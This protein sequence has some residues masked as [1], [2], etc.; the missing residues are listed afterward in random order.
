MDTGH[1]DT[2]LGILLL[3]DCS[4]IVGS[5]EERLLWLGIY[6]GSHGYYWHYSSRFTGQIKVG[7]CG[8]SPAEAVVLG[9]HLVLLVFLLLQVLEALLLGHKVRLLVLYLLLLPRCHFSELLHRQA[10]QVLG[11]RGSHL[12]SLRPIPHST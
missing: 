10:L 1:P 4:P 3:A 9:G 7:E 12:W 2:R 8:V 6:M 11:R 5:A